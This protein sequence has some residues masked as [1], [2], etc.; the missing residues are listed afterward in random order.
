MLKL[1]P[2]THD[3]YIENFQLATLK[4]NVEDVAQRLKVKLLWVQEE[5]FLDS[6][7]GI[8]YF[9]KIFTKEASQTDVDDIFRL[10]IT[11]EDGVSKL[12][13]YSSV[14]DRSARTFSI[15]CKVELTDGQVVSI[16][17]TL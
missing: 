5:W 12:I 6:S 10:A 13:D 7:Y 9:T 8:P 4:T 1:N 2:D 3:L 16:P 11:N 15:D 17:L 14:F